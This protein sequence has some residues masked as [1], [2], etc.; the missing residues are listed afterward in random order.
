MGIA[1]QLGERLQG[2]VVVVGVGDSR[3]GDDGV[4][5][6]VAKLLEEK[7]IDGVID[8]GT[9]PEIETWRIRELAPDTVVFVD[10]VDLGARPGD[11]AILEP[12]DLRASGYDTHRAPLKL[13]MRYLEQEL[14]CRCLL[15]AVQ[16]LD[17]RQDVPMCVQVAQSARNLAD[18]LAE[19]L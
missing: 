9:S 11:A 19:L 14:G 13:T 6:L 7:G 15:V 12:D 8:A 1:E 2:R 10:A 17:V 16:P 3:H 5:P 4:G 18:V